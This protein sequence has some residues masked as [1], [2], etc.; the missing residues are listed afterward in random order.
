MNIWDPRR[1][2]WLALAAAPLWACGDDSD[3]GDESSAGKGGAGVAGAKATGGSKP[4]DG[5]G[6][7]SA[8]EVGEP[9]EPGVGGEGGVPT[10]IEPS[11]GAGG[12]LSEAGSGG[13]GPSGEGGEG[14]GDQPPVNVCPALPTVLS[15]SGC[16]GVGPLCSVSQDDCEFTANCGGRLF[17]GELQANGNFTLEGADVTAANGAV[18]ETTCA[19]QVRPAGV[20]AS[21]SNTV[22]PTEGEASTTQC[23]LAVDPLVAPGISCIALPKR[24]QNLVLAPQ[25]PLTGASVTLGSCDI[26]QDGCNFQAECDNDV[27]FTGTATKTG[28]TFTRALTA[29]AAAQTPNATEQNPNPVPAFAAGATVNHSCPS[30]V[31]GTSVSGLCSAGNVGGGQNAKPATSLYTVT[32]TASGLPGSC[33]AIGP[34]TEE[35]FVLDSCPILEQGEGDVP[36]IGEPI[37]AFQQ[38]G[39]VWQVTCGTDLQ[40]GGVLQPGQ[41]KAEWRLPT[42]TPCEASFDAAGKLSGKC[43]V[44][45]QTACNLS[46]KAPVPA[47]ASCPQLPTTDFYSNG[48]GGGDPLNCRVTLQNGC[49]F[50]AI[51]DF[52]NRFPDVL[53]AGKASTDANG[54]DKLEFNGLGGRT[55]SVQKATAAEIADPSQFRV[56]GEWY[57]DCVLPAA[58]GGGGCRNNFSITEN[59]DG[60]FTSTGNYRGLRVYFSP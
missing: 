45:G 19:G 2:I 10:G 15:L 28:F 60:T 6:G 17:E 25:A 42:G 49:D 37:C 47:P 39:C 7:A 31:N 54:V 20:T 32:S 1:V 55:C 16:T 34:F 35:L 58:Q 3:P 48:C 12:E 52:S 26:I 11:A 33:N 9:T 4:N 22:T 46:S 36:G 21:C 30:T 29:L 24:L 51:C 59:E 27:V 41:T 53:F 56:E 13:T 43:T 5:G 23:Q 18:T 44:P 57:G 38:N 40:F 8:G 50:A 14:G